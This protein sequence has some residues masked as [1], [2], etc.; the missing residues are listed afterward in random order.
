MGSI[1]GASSPPKARV[2]Y[3]TSNKFKVEESKVFCD[4]CTLADGTRVRDAV[5]FE[6]RR[7]IIPETLEVDLVKM[8]R[9]EARVAYGAIK[10]PCIVEHAGLIF[11]E[12]STDGYPGGLTKP[13]WNTLGRRFLR[14]TNSKNRRAVARAVVGYCDGKTTS[15]LGGDTQGTLARAPRGSREF[16]WDTIL[17][18]DDPTKPRQRK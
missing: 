1:A 14:E 4:R 13:M 5:I 17:I 16:Y 18:P 6:I 10:V 7:L 8:V 12:Y 2:V 3:V 11:Q 9:E 15:A